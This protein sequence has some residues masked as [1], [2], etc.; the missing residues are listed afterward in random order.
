MYFWQGEYNRSG[1]SAYTF[2]KIKPLV[3]GFTISGL[4]ILKGQQAKGQ[5]L[6]TERGPILWMLKNYDD[7]QQAGQTGEWFTLVFE[8]TQINDNIKGKWYFE[9][10]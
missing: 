8:S 1:V 4:D 5:L 10:S 6:M 3:Y 2:E 9:N 7:R